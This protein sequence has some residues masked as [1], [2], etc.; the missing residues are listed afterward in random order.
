MATTKQRKTD[1]NPTNSSIVQALLDAR[2]ALLAAGESPAEIDAALAVMQ[3]KN[4]VLQAA[5]HLF[6]GH[7]YPEKSLIY[8]KTARFEQCRAVYELS[9]GARAILQIFSSIV[10]AD[11]L[12]SVPTRML[13]TAANMTKPTVVRAIAELEESGFIAVYK[14]AVQRQAAVYMI[15]PA[16]VTCG[17]PTGLQ[18]EFQ[19]LAGTSMFRWQQLQRRNSELEVAYITLPPEKERRYTVKIGTLMISKKKSPALDPADDFK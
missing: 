7:R 17:K 1:P 3:K 4:A 18:D 19:E 15:N 13:A 14:P 9:M 11:G 16:A 8:S 5:D 12:V 10:S 2:Q 6:N